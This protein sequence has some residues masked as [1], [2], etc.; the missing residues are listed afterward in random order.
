MSKRKITYIVILSL[1]VLGCAW[2]FISAGVIT[3]NFKKEAIN[4]AGEKQKLNIENLI[5]TETKEDK[6][7]WELYAESGYY[8]SQN[9][10][11]ILYN[12][13]GNFY[14]DDKVVLSMESS[15]GTF[16]E[17]T[18]KVVLYENSYFIY[19]DGT[20]VRAD[21]FVWQGN[22][23]DIVAQGNVIIRR[24]GE[25]R[26]FSNEAV[27]TNQMTSVRI[28]G[29]SKTELYSKGNFDEKF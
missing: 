14:D 17:E 23:K 3:K 29:R 27:L 20:D 21:R 18:K 24:N 7:Y 8:D 5:I 2:A 28:K 15:K 9:K 25:L 6:K 22:D 1:V 10:V 26:T 13:I 16:S 11:A 12:V 4:N 19:K